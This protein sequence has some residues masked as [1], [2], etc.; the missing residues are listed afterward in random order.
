MLQ[1]MC[2]R[3]HF[4]W[5]ASYITS[6]AD[7]IGPDEGVGRESPSSSGITVMAILYLILGSGFSSGE[8]YSGDPAQRQPQ[9]TMV[10]HMETIRPLERK[11]SLHLEVVCSQVETVCVLVQESNPLVSHFMC[12]VRR[13]ICVPSCELSVVLKGLPLSHWSQALRGFWL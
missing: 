6:Q 3:G 8:T 13:P 11:S 2:G 5:L 9:W 1:L 12:R 10:S 7:S 4:V